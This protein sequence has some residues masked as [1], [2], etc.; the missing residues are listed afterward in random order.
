M[1]TLSGA[2]GASFGKILLVKRSIGA[3]VFRP[4]DRQEMVLSLDNWTGPSLKRS[5]AVRSEVLN[6]MSDRAPGA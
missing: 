1:T 3:A 2:V 6:V 4:Q 5:A